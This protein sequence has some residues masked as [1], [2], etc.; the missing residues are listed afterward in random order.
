MSMDHQETLKQIQNLRVGAIIRTKSAEVAAQAIEAVISGGFRMVEFTLTTPDALGLVSRFSANE[1][2][3]VGAGTVMS[4]EQVRQVVDA[5]ARFIVSPIFDPE[6]VAECV[7]LGVVSIPGTQTPTEMVAADRAGADLIKIFPSPANLPLFVRQ[8]R[9][10]LPHL[11]LYPTAGVSCENYLDVL[12]AGAFGVGFVTPLFQPEDL[13][14]G[15]FEAIRQRAASIIRGL[16][17]LKA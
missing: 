7:R 12:R 1:E 6:V 4:P 8:V 14:A 13:A 17:D 9:G 10:P 2:L 3:L 16:G 15:D 11:R 5:G